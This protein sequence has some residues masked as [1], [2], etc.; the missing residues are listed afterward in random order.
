[1]IPGK[2]FVNKRWRIGLI[3]FLVNLTCL[4]P[5]FAV[6]K[7]E[8]DETVGNYVYQDE[9]TSLTEP[10]HHFDLKINLKISGKINY[11]LGYINADDELQAVFPDFDGSP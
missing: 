10:E 8:P 7:V 3:A 5:A 9:G 2:N 6:E 4:L 1:M 11:D